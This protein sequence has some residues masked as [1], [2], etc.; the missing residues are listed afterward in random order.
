LARRLIDFEEAH[1][2][3]RKPGRPGVEPSAEDHNLPNASIERTCHAV[4]DVPRS[5]GHPQHHRRKVL[6]P[7]Q[8]QGFAFE[9]RESE[10]PG[11]VTDR[12]RA[13]RRAAAV[14]CDHDSR[15]AG[16]ARLGHI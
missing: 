13:S 5:E 2:F 6:V 7:T 16:R 9:T 15:P 12:V 3:P 14:G 11:V 1:A 10:R 8:R 4:V